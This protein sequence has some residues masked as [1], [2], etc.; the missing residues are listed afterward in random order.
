MGLDNLEQFSFSIQEKI[1]S[2][3]NV[4]FQSA[5]LQGGF[6]SKVVM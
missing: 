6:Y 3:L 2:K 5:G 4:C 1:S